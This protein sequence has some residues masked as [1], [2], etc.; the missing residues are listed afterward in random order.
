M[1]ELLRYNWQTD[2]A[3]ADSQP[4]RR[5]LSQVLKS[6]EVQAPRLRMFSQSEVPKGFMPTLPLKTRQAEYIRPLVMYM[7]YCMF[8]RRFFITEPGYMGLATGEV[9]KGDMVFILDGGEVPYILRSKE[10]KSTKVG[11]LLFV[12]ESYVHGLMRGELFAEDKR[13]SIV[14]EIE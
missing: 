3:E 2:N 11:K 4:S 7:V 5:R 13:S 6:V 14:F 1:F 9:R 10:E 8:N 12:G